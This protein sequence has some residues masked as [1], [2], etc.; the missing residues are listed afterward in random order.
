MSGARL[1]GVVE[2]DERRKLLDA[3]HDLLPLDDLDAAAAVVDEAGYQKKTYTP[4]MSTREE[5]A[6]TRA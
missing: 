6:R 1:V 2:S 3:G 4:G 5:R